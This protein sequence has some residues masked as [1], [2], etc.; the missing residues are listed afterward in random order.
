[1]SRSNEFCEGA[2]HFLKT[3]TVKE[4]PQEMTVTRLVVIVTVKE[5]HS[6]LALE[7]SRQRVPRSM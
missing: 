5:R 2:E 7:R 1:M 4:I 6:D 3:E